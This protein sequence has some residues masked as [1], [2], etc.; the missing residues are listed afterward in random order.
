MMGSNDKPQVELFYAFNLDNV[1]P[2]DHL[3]RYVDRLLDFTE[4]REHLA[5]YYSHSGRPGQS[6]H[7]AAS[8][9]AAHIGDVRALLA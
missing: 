2:Q 1:V 6:L 8:N 7:G 3:L 4:L 5:P 9:T